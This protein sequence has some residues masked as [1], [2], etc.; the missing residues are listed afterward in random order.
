MDRRR[1]LTV[2]AAGVLGATAAM[3]L[4][5]LPAFAAP[6]TAA[7]PPTGPTITSIA[8][9]TALR[10]LINIKNNQNNTYRGGR[11]WG[12][13]VDGPMNV[14]RAPATGLNGPNPTVGTQFAIFPNAQNFRFTVRNY[15]N[16]ASF[17]N[18]AFVH[19]AN[20]DTVES[21]YDYAAWLFGC[22]AEGNTVHAVAHH[23]WHLDTVGIDGIPF[24]LDTKPQIR[25]TTRGI[26]WLK[27]TDLGRTWQQKTAA[28]ANRLLVVPEPYNKRRASTIYGW[29]HPSNIVQEGDYYYFTAEAYNLPHDKSHGHALLRVIA[30]FSLFRMKN[31][32]NV[33]SLEFYGANNKWTPRAEHSYQGSLSAQQPKVFFARHNFSAY[34][35]SAQTHGK[36][37]ASQCIR[38]HGPTN[39]WLIFGYQHSVRPALSFGRTATL[40]DP[41]FEQN[42]LT[43]IALF[44]GDDSG[45]Y[46]GDAYMNV[47]DP[48]YD[49]T[50]QNMMTIGNEPLL[51][52]GKGRIMYQ[53]QK[54]L[55][56]VG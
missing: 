29:L 41:Q 11:S 47:F 32:D 21:H 1:F 48:H 12:L 56:T 17:D 43:S 16:G 5:E 30:G 42:E 51:V 26:K 9:K 18:L 45:A 7:T 24:P 37:R 33:A 15:E 49:V 46:V 3:A 8:A 22:W 31:L 34:D 38:K 54:L 27:S 4:P 13:W 10:P 28:N 20:Y 36:E 39:Q 19:G 14:F 2:S 44:P 6:A 35:G 25:Y 55:I 52:V 23:E 50:D 40:A 53:Q